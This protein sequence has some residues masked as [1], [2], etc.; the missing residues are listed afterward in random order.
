MLSPQVKQEF[1]CLV[2]TL[3]QYMHLPMSKYKVVTLGAVDRTHVPE[4]AGTTEV[5]SDSKYC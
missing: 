5:P 3:W 2:T 1:S 4:K